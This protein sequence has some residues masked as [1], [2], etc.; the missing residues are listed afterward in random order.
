MDETER[1]RLEY[2]AA[3]EVVR[4]LTEVRFKLLALV[5][6]LAGAVVVLASAHNAG[7]ELLAIGALGATATSGVLV[8]ELRNSQIRSA[9]AERVRAFEE[10]H[11]ADGP[12]VAPPRAVAGIPIGHT[13]GVALVYG[14][15]LAG[16]SYLVAWGALRLAGL[17]HPREIGLALGAAA[18]VAAVQSISRF[19]SGAR[20]LPPPASQPV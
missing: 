2:D 11:F 12:L 17:G 13:L 19:E 3:V 1:L 10:R 20:E 9:A 14:A 5:P 8:Y 15:A 4:S 18:G 7:I 16:W 6:T